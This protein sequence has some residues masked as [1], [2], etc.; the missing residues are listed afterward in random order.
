MGAIDLFAQFEPPQKSDGLRIHTV[1][2]CGPEGCFAFND[3][4]RLQKVPAGP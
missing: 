1:I 3:K 2:V 4:Q